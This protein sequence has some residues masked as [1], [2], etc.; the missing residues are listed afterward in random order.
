[1]DVSKLT[2]RPYQEEG[3]AGIRTHY[4][5]G[6]R[7]V[8]LH[9]ATGGGKTVV[10]CRVLAGAIEKNKKAIMVV[11]GKQLVDNASQRLFREGIDHGCLQA[12]HWNKKPH[13]PL[14]VC[15]IDTLF[16][17]KMVPP[18]DLIVIDEA[19]YATS[20][21]FRWL[22]AQYPDAFILAVTATPHVKDGLRHI[23]DE[24]VYPITVKELM[25]QGFLVKPKYYVPSKV[26][27][28]GVRIDSKTGDFNLADLANAYEKQTSIYGDVIKYYSSVVQG[29]PAVCFAVDK[30]HSRHLAQLFNNAGF[31]AVHVEDT[32]PMKEREEI[33]KKLATGE[34][35]VV[36]NVGIFCVGVD[37][38]CL[39]AVISCRP[40]QSYNL[41]IQQC[42]RGTRPYPN[43]DHFFVMDHGDNISRHGF[44]EFERPCNLDGAVKRAAEVKPLICE[45]CYGAFSREEN[46]TV[47]PHCGHDNV[48]SRVVLREKEVRAEIELREVKP[49]VEMNEAQ[50][51]TQVDKWIRLANS[52]N[53]HPGFVFHKVK[54]KYGME[55][56]K[57]HWVTIKNRC[58]Q[59]TGRASSDSDQSSVRSFLAKRNG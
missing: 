28:R 19:H 48:K 54:D 20:D 1:M 51:A 58:A 30:N 4:G 37:I 39:R 9:L 27:M 45:E 25:D 56:A 59:Q 32:T 12:D 23:A 2:L 40:T 38:P 47:C 21:S 35:Q 8:L 24:V 46:G 11:R 5:S 15:S 3:I 34:I 49:T 17:R 52:R 53:Y 57:K 14:Q 55:V 29:L 36:T 26:D 31:K 22:I 33:I 18:A 6:K 7:R 10:F 42:G 44:I 43:K 13:H 50:I 16:R 41:W